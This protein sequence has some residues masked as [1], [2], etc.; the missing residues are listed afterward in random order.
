LRSRSQA[1]WSQR[2]EAEAAG[3]LVAVQVRQTPNRID[4][5]I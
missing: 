1:D 2:A 4:Y 3:E 5:Q